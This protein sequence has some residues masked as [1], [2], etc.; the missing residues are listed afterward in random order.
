MRTKSFCITSVHPGDLESC[1]Y[2]A[3][4]LDDANMERLAD[5]LAD[6]YVQN[7][8]W[9]DLEMIAGNLGIPKRNMI[10]MKNVGV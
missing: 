1:G 3:S 5:K 2:D 8:F 9:V 4:N 6:T 7:S 10:G